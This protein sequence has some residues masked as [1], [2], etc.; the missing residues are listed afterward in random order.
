MDGTRRRLRNGSTRPS[1]PVAKP[2]PAA[3]G[4]SCSTGRHGAGLVMHVCYRVDR[5]CARLGEEDPR[6]VDAPREAEQRTRGVEARPVGG[7]DGGEQSGGS[8]TCREHD[9]RDDKEGPRM[10]GRATAGCMVEHREQT[11]ACCCGDQQFDPERPGWLWQGN[12]RCGDC[13]SG[14]GRRFARRDCGIP[15]RWR[16]RR[17]GRRQR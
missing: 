3:S 16:R 14:T 12:Q 9:E 8:D 11:R 10:L 6:P 2:W 15:G 5:I 17:S 4:C 13:G 1:R 7:T